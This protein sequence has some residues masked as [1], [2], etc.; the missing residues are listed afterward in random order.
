M[1]FW[2]VIGTTRTGHHRDSKGCRSPEKRVL[3]LTR[4]PAFRFRPPVKTANLAELGLLQMASQKLYIDYRYL[5]L[6]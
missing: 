3:F 4:T 1:Y 6:V 5:L 2:Q